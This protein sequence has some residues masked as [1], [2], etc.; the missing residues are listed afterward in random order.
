MIAIGVLAA[1]WDWDWFRPLVAREASAALGRT[2][3][4]QHF[5]LRLGR[6]TAAVADGVRIA[7]PTGFAQDPPLA[8]VER[9]MVTI[10]TMELLRHRAVVVPDILIEQPQ[11]AATQAE[12]GR[13]NY[14]FPALSSGGNGPGAKVGNLRIT[15]AH[16]VLARLRTD[17]NIVVETHVAD[18]T[19]QVVAHAT[20]SYAGQPINADFVGAAL[21]SLR[22]VATPYPVNLKVANGPTHATLVGNVQDPLNF[23]LGRM[24]K[25]TNLVGGSGVFGGRAVLETTGNSMATMLANG[26]GSLQL[27]MAGGGDL[28]ALLVDLSGLQFGN[29]LLSAL[30]VPDRDKI[31]CFVAYFALRA[32]SCRRGR[33]CWTPPATSSAAVARSTYARRA[34]I[35][36]S[37]PK[38][39][40]LRS[41]HWPRR[42]P[43]PA[44]LNIPAQC[45]RLPNWRSAAERR[46]GWGCCFR[47]RPS[48]RLSNSASATTT[49]ARR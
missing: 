3:T 12:D 16:V 1:V 2:V 32:A 45:L 22:D 31:E 4:L 17:F 38:P 34:W 36:K 44:R 41:A 13:A 6:L 7:N 47:R 29:A 33:C 28:S 39:S 19:P 49:T 23:A 35:T 30:G 8:A 37:E 46:P 26:N 11:I 10:D 48:C 15:G 14:L 25:A 21:L 20:G 5:D 18:G 42:F 24:L 9:L 27:T 43:L 40:T